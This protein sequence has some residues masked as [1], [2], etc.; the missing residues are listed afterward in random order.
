MTAVICSNDL[1]AVRALHVLRQLGRGVPQDLS[2]TGFDDISWAA[3]GVEAVTFLQKR[4]ADRIRRYRHLRLRVKLVER[5]SVARVTASVQ[6]VATEEDQLLPVSV[7][8]H[9]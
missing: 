9:E 6:N 8:M 1:I 5:E 2:V 7:T 4:I 3:M